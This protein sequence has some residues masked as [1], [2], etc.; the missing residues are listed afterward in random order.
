[1][2]V[3]EKSASPTKHTSLRLEIDPVIE[4]AEG[5][6][7]HVARDLPMHPGLA[8]ASNGVVQAAIE[9]KRVS[10]KLGRPLGWHRLPAGFLIISVGLLAIW[11]Y[12]HFFHTSTLVIGVSARDAVQLKRQVGQRIQIVPEETIGS[13]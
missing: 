5:I 1:M 11:V 3:P 4:S 13:G 10:K 6:V 9:A 8:R 7:S 2:S 12:W